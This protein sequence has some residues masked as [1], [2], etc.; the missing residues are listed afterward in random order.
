MK[1]T[2]PL[3]ACATLTVGLGAISPA[4]AQ[5]ELAV[6]QPAG[7]ALETATCPVI[8]N[9]RSYD[10][11]VFG[12]EVPGVMTALK[13][14]RELQARGHSSRV[15]I[16]TEGDTAEGIGGHLVRGGLAYLD[17]NQ[18]PAKLQSQYGIFGQPS[19]LYQEFLALAHVKTIA[20]DRNIA[21][22]NFAQTLQSNG[23]E[24]SRPRQLRLSKNSRV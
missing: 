10:T 9:A 6:S 12:D 7:T 3:F 8:P 20:L 11:V 24:V 22:Q 1:R 2:F 13:V 18:V 4:I 15:A 21:A 19:R 14:K 16:V 5:T 23:I 17:R